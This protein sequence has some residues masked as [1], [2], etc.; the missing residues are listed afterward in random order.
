M[1]SKV[2][3]IIFLCAFITGILTG[4]LS[5]LSEAVS[6]GLTQVGGTVVMMAGGICFWSGIMELIRESGISEALQRVLKLPIRLIYGKRTAGSTAADPIA[7][8]M[9]ANILGLGSAATPAGLEAAR[10]LKR[11]SEMGRVEKRSLTV[12]VAM[13]TVSIQLI[14]VTAASIRAAMGSSDPYGILL[15]VWCASACSLLAAL[16]FMG[17]GERE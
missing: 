2:V 13:N 4:Q 16:A 8:N 7:R 3:E 10:E 17:R 15:P 14:P 11:L 5:G 1:L 6:G 9:A 12:L